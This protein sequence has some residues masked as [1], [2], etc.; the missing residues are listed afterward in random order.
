MNGRAKAPGSL[1]VGSLNVRGCGTNEMKRE[2]IGRMFVRRK[3][4]VLALS[5]TKMKGKGDSEFGPVL[6]RVSGVV[7][8]RGREGVGLLLSKDMMK[9]VK[10]WCEVSSR[11]MWVRVQLGIEKWIFVSAYGPGSEKNEEEREMFWRKLNE[12]IGCFRENVKVVVLGDLNA[13]VGNEPVADVVGMC[14]VEGRNDSG[15]ELIGLC[16]EQELLIGNTWFK[17]KDINKYTWERVER[18]VMVD[19]ALMDYVIISRNVRHRLLDVHVYRG[20]AVGVSDHYLVEGRLR[21]AERWRP[22]GGRGVG[23]MCIRV[24]ELR[25]EEKKL[26]YQE[27]ISLRWERLG[28]MERR[29]M[30]E[31]WNDLQS[32]VLEV[33]AEVCGYRRV[34]AGRRKGCEWWNERVKEVV[35]EKKRLFE[36]W[37][38]GRDRGVWER[39]REKKKECLREVKWAKR[40]ARRR[41]GSRMTEV[42]ARDRAAF[43]RDVRKVRGGNKERIQTVKD[44]NG[45]LIVE[46]ANVRER[47]K[48]HFEELLSLEEEREAIVS[49]IGGRGGMPVLGDLNDRPIERREIK[50]AVKEMKLEKA[51]GLDGITPE[52]VKFGGKI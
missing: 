5:E 42:F 38:Q 36:E 20:A 30:E 31:E 49:A 9:N 2:M 47:F 40:Q 15:E 6:G 48:E 19:R 29:G 32:G 16:L 12:C 37:L 25:K 41:E 34:G 45:Q 7:G 39:Y 3:L 1:R 17:K 22:G 50:E 44:K 4:D 13:R 8:G 51:A 43:W 28:G 11:I 24:R 23:R 18:G 46:E 14:G 10:E 26:E 27:K 35:E 21:V 52:L 33:G